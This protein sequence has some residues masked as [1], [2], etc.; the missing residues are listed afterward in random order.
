MQ[1]CLLLI[2]ML[3][4]SYQADPDP[5]T[6][7]HVHL[8]PADSG[9]PGKSPKI[10]PGVLNP[11]EADYNSGQPKARPTQPTMTTVP[12]IRNEMQNENSEL[13]EPL[14]V[15]CGGH[16]ATYC[17]RCIERAPT[18]QARPSYCNGQCKWIFRSWPGNDGQCVYKGSQQGLNSVNCGGHRAPSC[19]LCYGSKTSDP[20]F[21]NFAR[22]Q[23]NGDCHWRCKGGFV[24]LGRCRHYDCISKLGQLYND[25]RDYLNQP[26]L[27]TDGA[28]T[29][30]KSH[31]PPSGGWKVQ[32]C[33]HSKWK[34]ESFCKC[35]AKC[36]L[37]KIAGVDRVCQVRCNGQTVSEV[38]ADYRLAFHQ[39]Q[40]PTS[41]QL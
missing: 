39:W 16:R 37:L 12:S 36:K 22:S 41:N 24:G 17:G 20:G 34:K 28:E 10:G 11:R 27:L 29:E 21:N 4:A 6:H 40:L 35:V 3:F 18:K 19:G 9:G 1:H 33:K 23:C 2:S 26:N 13:S 15:N 32:D 38:G 7:L 14:R 8:P 25:G 31:S 30:F 5:D